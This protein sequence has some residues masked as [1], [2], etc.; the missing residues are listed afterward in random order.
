MYT[1]I[2]VENTLQ[3]GGEETQICQKV[4]A[5]IGGK[6]SGFA[7]QVYE[8]AQKQGWLRWWDVLV[9]EG[10]I[11]GL[12]ILI[13]ERFDYFKHPEVALAK[14]EGYC[15]DKEEIEEYLTNFQNM[16]SEAR[17]DKCFAKRLLLKNAQE[18]LVM[19]SIMQSGDL[20]YDKLVNDL[21]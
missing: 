2:W 19:G 13:N 5:Y 16:Q 17:I 15:Q 7:L 21:R 10:I 9:E 20:P 3:Q 6:A 1:Q 4:V 8:A 12:K 18:D 14:L 11:T